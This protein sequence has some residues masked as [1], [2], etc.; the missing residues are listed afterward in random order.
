V[1]T[2][3]TTPTQFLVLCVGQHQQL[4]A[5]RNTV[6]R[7]EGYRVIEAYSSDDALRIF[8]STDLDIVVICHSIPVRS[9]RQLVLAMKE[10]RPLIPVIA[11]HEA[12]DFIT[13]ADES[14]DQLAGPEAL[15]ECM[16]S[17][18]KKPVHKVAG[19]GNT[20]HLKPSL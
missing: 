17:L 15:L 14:V 2:T 3:V 19:H 13:E 18:L 16:A 7:A 6:L 5:V 1:A 10:A 11:L 12:Y 20:R 8:N 9:R 4:L